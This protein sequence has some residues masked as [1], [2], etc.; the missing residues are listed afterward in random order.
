VSLIGY[1]CH[2]KHLFNSWNIYF[3]SLFIVRHS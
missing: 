1:L 2:L 3:M